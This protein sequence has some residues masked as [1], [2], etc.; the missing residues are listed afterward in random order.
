M[1]DCDHPHHNLPYR[2]NLVNLAR[3][4]RREMT[5]AEKKLWYLLLHDYKPR[6]LKQRPI[7]S[8]IVDFY[9]ASYKLVIELDGDVHG[10]DEAEKSD[11]IREN[12][13]KEL[14]LQV[15]RFTNEDVVKN[16]D[17]VVREIDRV[18]G[19]SDE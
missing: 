15:I 4:L 13:L 9:C 1:S 10:T 8:Y 5:P 12:R 18:C 19:N 6:F 14:G 11:L 7:D 2:N 3:R 17:D 16:F